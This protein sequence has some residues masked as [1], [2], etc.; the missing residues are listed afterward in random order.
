MLN[1]AEAAIDAAAEDDAER[2]RNRAKLYAP[3]AGA[4]RAGASRP[5]ARAGAA[6]PARSMGASR[7]ARTGDSPPSMGDGVSMGQAQSIMAQLAAE[8]ARLAGGR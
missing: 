8:D 2:A 6:R 4:G 7:A 1:A 3:P 5:G